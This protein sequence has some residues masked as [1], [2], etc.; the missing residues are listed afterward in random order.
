MFCEIVHSIFSASFP[1]H[2]KLIF[3]FPIS[4]QTCPL[5]NIPA[6]SASVADATTDRRV[7]HS[8]KMGAFDAGAG[9]DGSGDKYELKM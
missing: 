7:L 8:T 1:E 5:W 4:Q 2:T 6:V 3:S 9:I